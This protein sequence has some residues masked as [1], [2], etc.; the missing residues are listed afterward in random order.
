MNA[1]VPASASAPGRDADDELLALLRRVGERCPLS[2]KRLYALTCDQLFGVICRI[3]RDRS[4]AEDVLQEVYVKVW[5]QSEQFD[6]VRGRPI[7]WLSGIAHHAAIDSLRRRS[8]RPDCQPFD[9]P[10]GADDPYLGLAS[11]NADPLDHVM[12]LASASA[13]L[14]SLASLPAE[15]RQSLTLAFFDGLS[16]PQIAQRMGRPPSTVKS[17]VR[18][19]LRVMR[20][21]LSAHR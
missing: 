4:E 20:G 17:W 19:T 15:Q 2:F 12:N 1:A 14:Q 7:H 11:S 3:N 8:A 13:L 5:S 18:R 6:A 9:S 10:F 21:G 16:Y